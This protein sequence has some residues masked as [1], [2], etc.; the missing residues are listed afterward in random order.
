MENCLTCPELALLL[1]S[2]NIGSRVPSK[3]ESI[4][5]SIADLS[6]GSRRVLFNDP[7]RMVAGQGTSSGVLINSH[8][9]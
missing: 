8:W 4:A 1:M 5:E 2:A 3:T 9:A 7:V 6:I